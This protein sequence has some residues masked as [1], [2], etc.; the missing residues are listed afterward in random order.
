MF[1]IVFDWY[2]FHLLISCQHQRSA[3][4]KTK[5]FNIYAF[6]CAHLL[7]IPLPILFPGRSKKKEHCLKKE[8]YPLEEAESCPCEEY[9]SQ[10]YGNWSACILPDPTASG[11]IKGWTSHREIKECGQGLRYK[12][13][14]CIDQQGH[15]V[16]PSLCTDTGRP[17]WNAFHKM[18]I[19][20]NQTLHRFSTV[21]I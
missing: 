17:H 16:N 15:L 8:L 3:S 7:Y 4:K 18:F 13:V 5:L 9:L 11:S 12:T 1:S 10:P 6:F 14:A 20:E 21:F 2:S 19:I